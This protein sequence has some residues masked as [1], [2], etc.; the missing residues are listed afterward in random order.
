MKKVLLVALVAVLFMV[1]SV[2]A[3]AQRGCELA[4][5]CAAEDLPQEIPPGS[6]EVWH[7]VTGI[8]DITAPYELPTFCQYFGGYYY[9]AEGG[10]EYWNAC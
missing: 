8:W 7:P 3:Y 2:P 5:E 10:G 6:I 9:I 1:I 4:H